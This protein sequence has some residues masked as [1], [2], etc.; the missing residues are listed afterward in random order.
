MVRLELELELDMA[1]AAGAAMPGSEERRPVSRPGLY[2]VHTAHTE[3][4][5][6]QH[7]TL[8]L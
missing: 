5:Q 2:R 4:A 8:R 6:L 3:T 7:F 1:A